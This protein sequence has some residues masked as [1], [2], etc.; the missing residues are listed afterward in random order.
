MRN[1][2]GGV[3]VGRRAASAARERAGAGGAIPGG[4][5]AADDANAGDDGVGWWRRAG[6]LRPPDG[7]AALLLLALNLMVV[8]VVVE[9]A[10]WA[11]TPN[12]VGLL[13]LGLLTAFA[14][15]RLPLWGGI[16]LLLG[17]ALGALTVV[18][19]MAS[20]SFDGR[21]LN[22]AAELWERLSLWAGAARTGAISIDQAPFSFGL[23]CAAW[24]LGFLGGWLFLRRRNFWGVF[25][26]GAAGL[27]SNL[28]FLP[29][30]PSFYLGLYLF[31]A[32]LLVARVQVVRRRDG[33]R[34]RG[35]HYD[36]NLGDLAFSDSL[37]LTL[38][39]V[40]IAFLLPAAGRWNP[41]TAAYETLRQP[42]SAWEDD[43][44][45]LFAGLPARRPLGFR[46]WDDVLAFQGT[47]NPSVTQVLL[48][49][50][51]M[52]LYWKARTYG[53]YTSKGWQSGDTVFNP[54]GAAAPEFQ[55][56]APARSRS[57]VTYSVTPLY[58]SRALFAGSRMLSA[59]PDI[60]LETLAPPVYAVDLTR[61]DPLA[62]YPD[63]LAE[64]GRRLAAAAQSGPATDEQLERLLPG[65]FRL[66][67]VERR[68]GAAA[69][70]QIVEA[71][72]WPPD[73][74]SVR[75]RDGRLDSG[76]P[77]QVTSA[78]SYAAP[79]ELRAAGISYP[80]HI[81]L[82]YTQLPDT[83]PP[84][85]RAL[86]A[87]LTAGI[88]TPYDQAAAVES[89]LKG[90]PYNLAVQPPPFN[91]DGVD[92]F[93]FDQQQGYSEYFASAMAVLLR[94]AGVP[95][96]LAV[97]YTVG[98]ALEGGQTFSVKDSHSHAW[99]EAYFPHYGWIPF[100]PTPGAFLP[101]GTAPGGQHAANPLTPGPDYFPDDDCVDL[102]EFTGLCEDEAAQDASAGLETPPGAG[103]AWGWW[104]RWAGL[105]MGIAAL[106]GLAALGFWR[107]YLAASPDPLVAY[108]RLAALSRL[109][110][111]G[112]RPPQTPWQQ[113]R[114]L[115]AA[116]PG[117]SA[118][119]AIVVDT[120]VRRRY[121]NRPP[122]PQE[123]RQLTAAW[124]NLRYPLLR[125][126]LLPGRR[127]PPG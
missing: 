13:L 35:V 102:E 69:A 3:G 121:G 33:W 19:Q 32:L 16:A 115:A 30:N 86:A 1:L 36:E 68:D 21:E 67:A 78:P 11:P 29:P 127:R 126:I 108:R 74:L 52:P 114:Q 117:Q 90:L 101:A 91:G 34:R 93:L 58:A 56:S 2:A 63:P 46:L 98:D 80:P 120:F 43:F 100:E 76:Q 61:A 62:G 37:F 54:A 104:L 95:A 38:A 81:E 73:V 113:Q 103:R 88:A 50:S 39:V 72:P 23:V 12:L 92:H 118:H 6:A 45:R 5:A 9:R 25:L 85:V 64:T 96:R 10:D 24:L 116:L 71:L 122:T 84:R 42:L 112:P 53:V 8:V 79:A 119:I 75:G 22:G 31:T 109:A 51:P 105:P 70:A 66:A 15:Y 77:Y 47:I 55:V 48:V 97:G 124:Q 27:F 106:G 44:N 4:V 14:L 123:S 82:R 57:E 110:A 41:A 18:W 125:R 94:A 59:S 111:L 17:L 99:V 87:E 20:F 28:T 60:E 49:E 7:W 83:L 89:W 65:G 107:R 40:C 26:L